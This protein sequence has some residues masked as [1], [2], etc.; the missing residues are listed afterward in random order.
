MDVEPGHFANQAP[1]ENG[2]I[3]F[4]RY[5]VQIELYLQG[6]IPRN[7]NTFNMLI[8]IGLQAIRTHIQ[9]SII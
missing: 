9:E 4:D 2:E 1:Q 3:D 6:N 5:I 7:D 8:Q